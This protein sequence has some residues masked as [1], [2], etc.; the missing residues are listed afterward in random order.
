MKAHYGYAD[1]S[2]EY[3][4]T[5]DT[6]KCDGCGACAQVCPKN[7][8]E[9]VP[10]DYDEIKAAVRAEFAKNLSYVCPGAAKCKGRPSACGDACARG[11]IG[12]TW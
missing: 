3:F 2:G 4:I 9:I 10:D 5:I 7:I 8:F 1:G 6:D 11:A 12:L